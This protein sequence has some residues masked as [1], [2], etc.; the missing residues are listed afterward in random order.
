MKNMTEEIKRTAPDALPPTPFNIPSA[1]TESLP[2]GLRLV[3]YPDNR[4]PL[5]SYRLGFF[6]GDVL[7]P[8]DGRGLTSAMASLLTEGTENHSSR[9]LAEKIE[10]LGASISA[11]SS[12]DFI[13][14]AASALLLYDNEILELMA[15]IVLRPAFPGGRTRSFSP[16]YDREP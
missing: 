8:D 14:V 10:Q 3:I 5:V 13:A 9:E 11:S 4:L 1:L 12:Y 15:E 2:N 7:D 16:K 6:R